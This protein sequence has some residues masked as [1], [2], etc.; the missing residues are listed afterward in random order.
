MNTVIFDMDGLLIDSEPMWR[1]AE[2]KVFTSLGVKVTDELAAQT[3]CMTTRAV[4]KFWYQRNPWRGRDL[5][6]VENDVIDEVESLIHRHG[7]A[8]P[9][10]QQTLE[11]FRQHQFSI[12]LATNSPARLIDAVLTNLNIKAFFDCTTSADEV[13]QGKPHPAIYHKTMHKLQAQPAC[14]IA[15]EDSLT[16]LKA[17]KQAKMTAIVVPAEDKFFNADFDLADHKLKSLSEL[18]SHHLKKA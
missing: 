5:Y 6:Q 15:I 16:G 13:E 1:E 8:L 10:V 12:G 7:K 4:T 3:A 11:L 17:A 2:H 18:Q 14:S 9:G